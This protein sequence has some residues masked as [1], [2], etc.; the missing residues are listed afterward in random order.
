V[1]WHNHVVVGTTDTPVPDASLEPRAL[2]EEIEFVMTHAAQYL[3][4]DPSPSDV[5]SVFAGLRPLVKQGE[6][7]NTSALSRDHT[8]LVSESGL[9]TITG[10]KW[11]I[12]RKMAQDV[13]DQ[14]EIIA[15]VDGQPCRTERLHIHGW[16]HE[17]IDIEHWRVYGTDAARL[18]LLVGENPLLAERIHPALPYQCGEVVWQTRHE[19]ARTV[20]DVLSRRTRMLLLKVAA[21]MA[22]ELGRDREWEKQQVETF[23]AL[24]CGYLFP[25]K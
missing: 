20:E 5:R 22:V 15:D 17:P 23:T 21:L 8:I 9:I 4:K 2:N 11:T 7:T 16:T 10:G 12:Y 13:I 24:A 19:M 14:A 25:E 18:K 6:G 1:P 3:S